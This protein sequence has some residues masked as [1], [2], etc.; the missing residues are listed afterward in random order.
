MQATNIFW[1]AYT[2]IYQTKVKVEKCTDHQL[3]KMI[4]HDMQTTCALEWVGKFAQLQRDPQKRKRGIM[5][6]NKM[7]LLIKQKQ[8]AWHEAQS[9]GLI[10]SAYNPQ[11]K[12][13]HHSPG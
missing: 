11:T 2:L 3:L 9:P 5:K 4:Q 6:S 7:W 12:H 8:S 13:L 10:P 1:F